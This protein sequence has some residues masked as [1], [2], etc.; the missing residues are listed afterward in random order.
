M[1]DIETNSLVTQ[2][3]SID[4]AFIKEQDD[5]RRAHEIAMHKRNSR[6]ELLRTSKEIIIENKRNKPVTEREVSDTE[7]IAFATA[8]ENFLDN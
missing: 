1:A 2:T 4:T 7:I 5:T 3:T 6:L 8:L